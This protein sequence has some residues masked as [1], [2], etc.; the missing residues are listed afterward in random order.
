[1]I[2]V[3]GRA[4]CAEVHGEKSAPTDL[5]ISPDGLCVVV[6]LLEDNAIAIL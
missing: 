4:T 2:D 5:V 1:V 6:Y 3:G